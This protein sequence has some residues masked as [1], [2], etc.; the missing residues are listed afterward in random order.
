[1]LFNFDKSL[2]FALALALAIT[3][4]QSPVGADQS[5]EI[6][7]KPAADSYTQKVRNIA[8]KYPVLYRVEWTVCGVQKRVSIG[9][10]LLN[11]CVE[12][13]PAMLFWGATGKYKLIPTHQ[14]TGGIQSHLFVESR[15]CFAVNE[16]TSAPQFFKAKTFIVG[17]YR[18]K[19]NLPIPT[20]QVK[21][22]QLTDSEKEAAIS[23]QISSPPPENFF[24][25][26][27]LDPDCQAESQWRQKYSN[28]IP[29]S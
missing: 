29:D 25:D 2:V 19:E 28:A 27:S 21:I 17:R 8:Q 14:Y 3:S 1:M 5:K 9:R 20:A 23:E 13:T 22:T 12:A 15:G 18:N 10:T 24:I 4:C 7:S 16:P 6:S 11:Q 26:I